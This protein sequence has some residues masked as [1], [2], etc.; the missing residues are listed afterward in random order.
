[1]TDPD[2]QR[3]VVGTIAEMAQSGNEVVVV[4]G[5]GPFIQEELDR[6]GIPSEFVE[7]LRRTPP[8]AMPHVSTALMRVN[9]SLAGL[10]G[11]F[12]SRAVGLTGRDARTITA[13]THRPVT[14]TPDGDEQEVDLGLVGDVGEVDTTLLETLLGQG[15]IPVVTCIA[16][17]AQG[18]DHNINAD[19]MA[20]H[21]AGALQVDLFL[22]LTDVDGLRRDPKDPSTLID[23]L[24]QE[25]ARALFGSSIQGG[26]IP[27]VEACLTAIEHGAGE[28]A[29]I[30]GTRPDAIRSRTLGGRSEGTTFSLTSRNNVPMGPSSSE[31]IER[32]V[33]SY[34]PT[35]ARLPVAFDRGRG[36]W[37]WDA[38]GRRYLDA[39]SGIAVTNLGHAHPGVT[40]RIREQ[41]GRLLHIS[42]FFVSRPQVELS[43][44]LTRA[45]GMDRVFFTNS[46]TE[47]FEGGV[48]LARK[49]AAALGRGP[50]IVSME[51]CFHG[52]TMAAMAAG[53]KQQPWAGPMPGGFVQ[54]PFNDLEAV[55]R[56]LTDE[57]AAIVLEPVQGEGGVHVSDPDHLRALRE[58]CDRTGCLLVFDEI[59]TGM[60]RTGRLFAKDHFEVRP[61]ILL[62][63][64]ALGNGMPVGA[65]L[66]TEAV[67]GAIAPGDHGTTFGGNPL[68]CAAGLAVLDQLEEPDFM[69]EVRRRSDLFEEGLES[70]RQ[71][72]EMVHEVRGL[73]LM[74]GVEL[75]SEAKPVVKQLLSD[76]VVANATAGNVLR[77]LPPLIIDDTGIDHLITAIGQALTKSKDKS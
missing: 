62:L 31:L 35:F 63:A 4:H 42:N 69:D 11:T 47:S 9:G 56:V 3:Q 68:A 34:V 48:K 17:D 39:L 6:A 61:D 13:H 45:A 70:L 38:D 43:E 2:L 26:M 54:V 72:H 10:F 16:T 44:R 64:K 41:A 65:F 36:A 60:G 33:K 30:N 14:T 71:E 20:G 66:A 59:Q 52:R 73:G 8:E 21:L 40:Q 15:H 18:R 25:Q 5:G 58:L 49:R 12:G 50:V 55:E 24:D 1:M 23:H 22:V 7:G 67:A 53:G 77:L 27:K 19:S 37:L 74:R 57:V 76:G 51:R 46:G 75:T 32:D 29:I 28:A